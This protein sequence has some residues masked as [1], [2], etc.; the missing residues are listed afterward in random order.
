M[1]LENL[2]EVI[3]NL[4]YLYSSTT[5]QKPTKV[6]FVDVDAFM[7]QKGFYEVTKSKEQVELLA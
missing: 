7:L 2:E 1:I 3:L 6:D 5:A 4:Y